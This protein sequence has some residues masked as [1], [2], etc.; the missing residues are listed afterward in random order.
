[1]EILF[2]PR[3]GGE[4]GEKKKKKKERRKGRKKIIVIIRGRTFE[5]IMS[6]IC[7]LAELSAVNISA[8]WCI[9]IV[10]KTFF[11]HTEKRLFVTHVPLNAQICRGDIY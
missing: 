2:V 7:P 1:L 5:D 4:G 6:T 9:F 11:S 8:I 3:G 10:A